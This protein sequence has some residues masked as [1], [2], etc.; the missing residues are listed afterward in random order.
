[1]VVVMVMNKIGS[2]GGY[3]AGGGDGG[4]DGGRKEIWWW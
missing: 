3:G 2:G 1:M 4:V